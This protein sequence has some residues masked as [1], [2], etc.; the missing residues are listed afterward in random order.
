MMQELGRN[1]LLSIDQVARLTGVKKS[2]LRYWE[3][4]FQDFLCPNRTYSKRREYSIDEVNIIETI[5]KL[6]EEEH[7]TN[8]GVKLRLGEINGNGP[9]C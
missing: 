2:T 6:I 8:M 7:L 5:K 4:T 3:K 9:S 1:I